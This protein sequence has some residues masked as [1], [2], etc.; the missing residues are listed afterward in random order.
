MDARVLLVGG[1]SSA[2]MLWLDELIE[3]GA[4]VNTVANG[5]DAL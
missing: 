4:K 1:A 2:A 5:S 3:A